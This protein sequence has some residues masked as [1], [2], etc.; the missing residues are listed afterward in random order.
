VIHPE[1]RS[2]RRAALALS[3]AS[4]LAGLAACSISYSSESISKS[5]SSP[6]KSS[7]GSSS[8]GESDSAYLDEVRS[9]SAGFG[10]SGG[11]ATAFRRGL[12]SIAERRGLHDWEDDD[13][14][15]KA[16]GEGLKRAGL[17]QEKAQALLGEVFA[18]RADRAGV[19]MKGFDAGA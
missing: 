17:T 12:G 10:S 14:T 7:S 6:F 1:P 3:L 18:G 5:V 9:F 15:C 13:P 2:P 4:L 16:I 8:G 19:A 11:D